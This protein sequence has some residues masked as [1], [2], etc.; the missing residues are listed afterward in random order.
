MVLQ[1]NSV[2]SVRAD[3]LGKWEGVDWM[4]LFQKRYQWLV[5]VKMVMN[6]QESFMQNIVIFL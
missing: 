4:H 3:K 5:L 2:T 1:A 6:L